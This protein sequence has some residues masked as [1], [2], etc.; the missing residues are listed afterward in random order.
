MDSKHIFKLAIG[1]LIVIIILR[2][3]SCN[4]GG[5]KTYEMYDDIEKYSDYDPMEMVNDEETFQSAKP[6]AAPTTGP[7]ATSVDL[8]P[9]PTSGSTDFGEFAPKDLGS[10]NFLDA[11]KFIGVDTQGSSLRNANYSL[12]RDPPIP[13][14]DIGPWAQSTIEADLY[15]K[16]LDC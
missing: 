6:S 16:T 2:M 13:R 4:Y 9:K 3:V 5:Q 14:S 8:L 10:Q 15:R 1:V 7:M 11:S 12:R